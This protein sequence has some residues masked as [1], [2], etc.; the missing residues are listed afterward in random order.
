M[1]PDITITHTTIYR[2]SIPMEP[3]AIATGT[4]DY[5]QNVLVRIHTDSGQTGLGE[6]SAFPMIV[7]ETQ[8]TCLVLAKEFACLWKG[9]N[10]LDIPSRLAELDAFIA[11]NRTIKSAF[12]MA[13]HDLAAK[14]AGLP[15]Y[16]FLGGQRRE[17]MTDI[18][19]GIGAPEDMAIKAAK[20]RDN[21]AR[22]LKIK[23]GKEPET[24]I[25]RIRAIREA[26]GPAVEIR[27][28]A[29]QGWTFAQAV[30]ALT[31]LAHYGIEFC[32]QP[33]RTHNDYLLPAL[34]RQ[35]AV[36]IM[37]DESVYTH[38]DAE[39]L[40]REQACN[41]IN[42]KL[43]KSGGIQEALRIQSTAAVHGVPCM[44]GGMLESRLAL[45]AK[46][47]FAYAADNVRFY[48]LDTCLVGH[49]EDPVIGGAQYDGYHVSVSHDPGIGADV[50]EAFL[51][52]CEQ[53]E[54]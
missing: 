46:V 10:P 32:E 36:R 12:D 53:W 21:G 23:V 6:C 11:G 37:A 1:I 15:L 49:L 29:N 43:S 24:D 45:A 22:T 33:M 54:L 40:C 31:G 41:Y 25:A 9:R 3:F 5:A 20:L 48:D 42:I 35:V 8:D 30:E 39:R 17:I 47:H 7:G 2:F 28:D 50:N 4:M 16:R 52:Q 27:V 44:I 19:L 18:T 38:H 51:R 14:H 34:R 13:L 26:V